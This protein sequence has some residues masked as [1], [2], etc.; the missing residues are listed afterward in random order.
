MQ[1]SVKELG[2]MYG[3]NPALK[4]VS[5]SI[6]KGI[7]A[8]LGPNG[9]G[10]TTLLGILATLLEPTS[11]QATVGGYDVH[12]QRR[13]VRRILGFLPQ[14]FGLYDRLTAYEFLDYMSVL[15]EIRSRR[16]CVQSALEQVGLEHHA[17][18]RIGTFS[19]G[20]RQR[21]GIAQALLNTPAVLI[22]D[23]PTSGLDPAE[24]NRFRQL[25]SQLAIDRTVILSTHLV[26]DISLAAERVIVLHKGHIRFDGL[27]DALLC[28]A[29]DKVWCASLS[30]QT[31]ATVQQHYYVTHLEAK[32]DGVVVRF[33]STDVPDLPAKTTNPTLEEA[34]L[35][36]VQDCGT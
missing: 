30:R 35:L 24:R 18:Q 16:Q 7:T 34:Y 6:D 11:G 10:K 20:M 27:V 8:L 4:Q 19:G 17:K 36:L 25:L 9:A 14:S 22:V 29:Q 32:N 26:E 31:L 12:R 13:E 5:F 15:K 28:S 23:E 21:L 3:R 1:I 33:L 2:K